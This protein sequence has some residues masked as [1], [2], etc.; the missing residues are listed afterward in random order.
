MTRQ[1]STGR[2]ILSVSMQP[3]LHQLVFAAA[4]SEDVPITVWVRDAIKARLAAMEQKDG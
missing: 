3:D 2:R 4:Q 1:H